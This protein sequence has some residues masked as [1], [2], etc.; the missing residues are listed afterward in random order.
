[1]GN[2]PSN[3]ITLWQLTPPSGDAGRR[4][5]LSSDY[6]VLEH[7]VVDGRR[8]VKINDKEMHNSRKAMDNG[9]EH[10]IQHNGST[11][12][13]KITATLVSFRYECLL[14]NKKLISHLERPSAVQEDLVFKVTEVEVDTTMGVLDSPTNKS[15]G[16]HFNGGATKAGEK[17]AVYTVEVHSKSSGCIVGQSKHR[18]SEFQTLYKTVRSMWGSSHLAKSIPPPPEKQMKIATNHF[19]EEFVERRREGLNEFMNRLGNFPGILSVPG[20]QEFLGTHSV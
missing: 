13:V 2:A 9:S 15:G 6:M 19:S 18:F 1:M 4:F 12:T 14:N 17:V 11:Y 10:L 7:N 5:S 16:S 8:V 3:H 20:I